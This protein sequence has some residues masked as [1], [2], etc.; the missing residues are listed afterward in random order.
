MAA[1]TRLWDRSLNMV[2]VG[3]ALEVF[4][5]AG[6]TTGVGQLVISID[7]AL[8]TLQRDVRSGQRESGC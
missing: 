4:Q 8:R 3:C 7:V 6:D 2:G 1:L 5:V